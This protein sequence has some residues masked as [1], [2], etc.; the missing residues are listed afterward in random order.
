MAEPL[1]RV[2]GLKVA[3]PDMAR[4]PLLGKAPMIEILKGDVLRFSQIDRYG[5]T[6]V[7]TFSERFGARHDAGEI[8]SASPRRS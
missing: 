3:L 2:R 7:V 1:F 6:H 8:G 4:K 5:R